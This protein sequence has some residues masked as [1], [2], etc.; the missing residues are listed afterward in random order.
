ML[1]EF[2]IKNFLSFKDELKF[3]MNP[4]KGTRLSNH[5]INSKNN[6]ILKNTVIFGANASG[7]TNFVKALAFVK[8]LILR[9]FNNSKIEKKYFRL[10]DSNY[11]D[12]AEFYLEFISDNINYRYFFSYSYAD[13]IIYDEILDVKYKKEYVNIFTR[14]YI[15][16]KIVIKSDFDFKNDDDKSRFNIYST[17]FQNSEDEKMKKTFFIADTAKRCPVNSDYFKNYINVIRWFLNVI[18]IF[19]DTKFGNISQLIESEHQDEFLNITRSFDLNICKIKNEE[20]NFEELFKNME[21]NEASEMKNE[22]LND[23]EQHQIMVKINNTI[24]TINKDDTGNIT[25]KKMKLAHSDDNHLF[26]LFEESDG[27]QRLF[28]LIPLFFHIKNNRVVLI[29]EIDR[30][31]H[32]KV[33]KKFLDLFFEKNE[34]FQSQLIFTSHDVNLLDLDI[35]R[36]DEI[37][38]M[39]RNKEGASYLTSLNDYN[40]RFDKKLLKEYLMGEYGGIPK[41]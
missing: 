20:L 38:F 37:K 30:S 33:V 21:Q 19:P 13:R 3:S 25:V 15:D 1:K 5:I 17:D 9:G 2:K 7:K 27:T 39:N 16:S 35:F 24:A 12:L 22:I 40:V 11:F 29:D 8:D 18:I 32:T 23:L 31:L 14:N 10:L 36:Q 28:D 6:K 34:N 41:F 26:D 4:S